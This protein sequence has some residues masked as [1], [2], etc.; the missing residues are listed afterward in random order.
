MKIDYYCLLAI[1]LYILLLGTFCL[2]STNISK[3]TVYAIRYEYIFVHSDNFSA[4]LSLWF[5]LYGTY[6]RTLS[7]PPWFVYLYIFFNCKHI[8]RYFALQLTLTVYT[9]HRIYASFCVGA[10]IGTVIRNSHTD[11]LFDAFEYCLLFV[12]I[13]LHSHTNIPHGSLRDFV[14]AQ[15]FQCCWLIMLFANRAKF[16]I[17]IVCPL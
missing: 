10:M 13:S 8:S 16:S 4:K 11:S 2:H 9:T 14:R 1:Y 6:S 12:H 3:L 7:I 5:S 17:G 15:C